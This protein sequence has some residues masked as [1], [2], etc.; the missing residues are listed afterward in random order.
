MQLGSI[1]VLFDAVFNYGVEILSVLGEL[2]TSLLV[3]LLF[4][5]GLAE[6]V[7][8]GSLAHVEESLG[9]V[10][11]LELPDHLVDVLGSGVVLL[12]L[13]LLPLEFGLFLSDLLLE[14]LSEDSLL[15]F[16]SRLE[17]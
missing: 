2:V 11:V 4:E 10:L 16:L 15:Y 8:L 9:V 14:L 1:E 12:L 6:F 17:G 7:L 5:F 13:L 3:F